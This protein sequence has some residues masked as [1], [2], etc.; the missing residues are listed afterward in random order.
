[1]ETAGQYAA[2]YTMAWSAAQT[3]GPMTGAQIAQHYSFNWLWWLV[4]CLS[5]FYRLFIL[6]VV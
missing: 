1:M 6:Q 3:L 5:L 2:L 4:G